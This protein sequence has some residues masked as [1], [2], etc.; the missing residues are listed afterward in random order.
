MRYKVVVSY[1]GTNFAGYAIQPNEYTI[2]GEICRVFSIIFNED[3]KIYASGRTDKGVHA[4]NQVFHF[5]SEKVIEDLDKILI[6]ANKLIDKNIYFKSIEKVDE[7]FHA[8][9]SAKMKT[10]SYVIN[11]VEYS[12]LFKDLELFC[13]QLD[14]SKMEEASK[15]FIGIHNYQN[16]TSKE[17]DEDNYVRKIYDIKFIK[18][19]NRIFIEFTGNGFMKYQIRKM[20]GT[21]IEIG[22]G[23][24]TKN[25]IENKL[26]SKEREIVSYQS[27][28]KGLYLKEVIY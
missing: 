16:F 25:F 26:N 8:R 6:S 2:Q 15:L 9:F 10:Y 17:E 22:K 23:K 18:E 13:N 14:V 27:P 20:V 12:P 5:D 21:L 19:S 28:S 24:I 3:I 4:L 1:N 11:F 7:G